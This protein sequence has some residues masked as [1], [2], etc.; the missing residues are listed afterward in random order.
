M[1]TQTENPVIF[2]GYYS[3]S[4][5]SHSNTCCFEETLSCKGYTFQFASVVCLLRAF[6][7]R[8]LYCSLTGKLF[9]CKINLKASI[10]PPPGNHL[11]N[12]STK[13]PHTSLP[14][15]RCIN[16]L[17]SLLGEISSLTESH[18]TFSFPDVSSWKMWVSW[19]AAHQAEISRMRMWVR[20]G[21]SSVAAPSPGVHLGKSV[22]FA[23]AGRLEWRPF[24]WHQES[25]MDNGPSACLCAYDIK[26][27]LIF[28]PRAILYHR[29]NGHVLEWM[30]EWEIVFA[31]G[32]FLLQKDMNIL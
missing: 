12:A 13:P 31:W 1:K 32:C 15:H 29:G 14:T 11:T 26:T 24:K 17:E 6:P 16:S 5:L 22:G 30:G 20:A 27:H 10:F 19:E 18:A 21:L 4:H 25:D 9:A 23:R 2:C 3:G 8:S 28:E 7:W